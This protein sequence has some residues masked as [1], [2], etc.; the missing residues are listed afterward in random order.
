[1]VAAPSSLANVIPAPPRITGDATQDAVAMIQWMGQ[2]YRDGILGNG[3]LQSANLNPQF[4][5]EFPTLAQ[6]EAN[7]GS[8]FNDTQRGVFAAAGSVNIN[9]VGSKAFILSV[10]KGS[11]GTVK[12][13]SVIPPFTIDGT[14]DGSPVLSIDGP[15]PGRKLTAE[16]ATMSGGTTDLTTKQYSAVL[17]DSVTVPADGPCEWQVIDPK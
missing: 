12:T 17:T 5:A 4:T 15:T 3:I 13:N 8:M 1:M 10:S 11:A 9:P 6:I 16:G 7:G 2:F 14:S